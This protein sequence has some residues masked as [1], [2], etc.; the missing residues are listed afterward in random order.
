[1]TFDKRKSYGGIYKY[2]FYKGALKDYREAVIWYNEH[3]EEVADR[4]IEAVE[5]RIAIICSDP[6]RYR[7]MYQNF[8]EISVQSFPYTIV[9]LIKKKAGI[10]IISSL[11]HHKRNPKKKYKK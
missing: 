1:M 7:N 10:V 4:F 9:Y 3:N 8:Y 6:Y 5:N 11:Y 2:V